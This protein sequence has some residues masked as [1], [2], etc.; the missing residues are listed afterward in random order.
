MP[1]S[2]RR[3][4]S[5]PEPSHGRDCRRLD[6]TCARSSRSQ[7][8]G[9]HVRRPSRSEVASGVLQGRR[10]SSAISYGREFEDGG[11]GSVPLPYVDSE[12]AVGTS[13]R[14]TTQYVAQLRRLLASKEEGSSS[15]TRSRRSSRPEASC[16]TSRSA[17]L[18]ASEWVRARSTSSSPSGSSVCGRTHISIFQVERVLGGVVTVGAP[19]DESPLGDE[20]TGEGHGGAHERPACATLDSAADRHGHC[21]RSDTHGDDRDV[22]RC[23]ADLRGPVGAMR[24]RG[25][26]LHRDPGATNPTYVVTGADVG[27][28]LRVSVTAQNAA[29]AGTAASARRPWSKSPPPRTP[30]C[31]RSPEPRRSARP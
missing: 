24:L 22:G 10:V 3:S 25:G 27:S 21:S 28:A 8:D 9:A 11:S 14:S 31:R 23:P 20:A 5:W 2:R 18:A 15:S 16:R 26:A 4:F 30:P 12:A 1:R 6:T 29:G 17:D 13:A 19:A 7:A